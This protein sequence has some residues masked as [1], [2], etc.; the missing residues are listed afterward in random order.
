[1]RQ[2]WHASCIARE[3]WHRTHATSSFAGD[4]ERW[5]ASEAQPESESV[6]QEKYVIPSPGIFLVP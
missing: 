4:H 2:L 1:M 5:H 3:L 6:E